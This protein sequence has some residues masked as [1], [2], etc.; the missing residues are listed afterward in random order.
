[1]DKFS[2][3]EKTHFMQPTKAA[4]IQY[5]SLFLLKKGTVFLFNLLIQV[6]SMCGSSP[7]ESSGNFMA[8]TQCLRKLKV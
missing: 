4:V 8:S 5:V 6:N 3:L 2:E 7:L 1:M